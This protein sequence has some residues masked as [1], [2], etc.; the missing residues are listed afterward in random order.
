M[1]NQVRVLHVITGLGSG[2]AEMF[3]MNMYRNMDHEKIVF[4]FLLQSNENIYREELAS[5]GSQIWQIP[6]YFKHP[7]QNHTEL[8]KILA[9]GYPIIHVHAN[10][11]MYITPILLAEKAGVPCRIMHSHSTSVIFKWALPYHILNKKRVKK[12]ATHCFACSEDAGVWMFGS[13]YTVIQNAIELDRFAF[14][15][16]LR[17]KYRQE[18]GIADDELVIGQIGRLRE[19]KNQSFSLESFRILTMEKANCRL[20]FV[21][22]GSDEAELREKAQALGIANRVSFLGVRTDV[23]GLMNAF[24]L[25]LFPSLY[26]GLGIVTVEAQANGLPV[27]C[28]T[29][30][31]ESCVFAENV[32]RRSL[33]LGPEAWAEEILSM[34]LSRTDN[35]RKLAEAGFDI[36]QAAQKL[37]DFYIRASEAG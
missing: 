18:L 7:L 36:R 23:S 20:L 22:D 15:P 16:E 12:S 11:L 29:A 31:P 2:G 14:C 21:G 37:Q 30:V 3:L 27:V 10:A 24:D 25:L 4:D 35:W 8:K 32:H 19:L 17:D 9:Q 13:D 1:K 5:Y 34:D 6:P 26:E 28:S 33:E